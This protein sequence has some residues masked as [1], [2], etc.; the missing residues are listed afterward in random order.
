[1][2]S[3]YLCF[4]GLKISRIGNWEEKLYVKRVR[5]KT[6]VALEAAAVITTSNLDDMSALQKDSKVIQ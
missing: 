2:K 6:N 3:C 5:A 4:W 1:M